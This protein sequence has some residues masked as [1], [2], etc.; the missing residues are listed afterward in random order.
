MKNN[1]FNSIAKP[2]L[3]T[4]KTLMEELGNPHEELKCIHI[5]GTNGKGSVCAF[6]QCILTTAGYKCGKYT[7]PH[8]IDER[9]R[10][11]IDGINITKDDI[12]S[13]KSKVISTAR[14]LFSPN[15]MPTQFEIW[16]ACAFLYFKEQNCDFAIIE[17]GLGGTKDATNIIKNPIMSVITHIALD[18]TQ[19]LG[20]TIKKIA[21]EKAGII[22]Q[23]EYG[24][25]TVT[26]DQNDDIALKV[27]EQ[28]AKE[29]NNTF[30]TATI[31]TEIKSHP[32]Y[33]IFNYK[34]IQNIKNYM[35]GSYQKENAAI[36]IECAKVLKISDEDIKIGISKAKNPGRF[37]IINKSPLIIFD[38]AHNK[39]GMEGLKKSLID[40]FP[41]SEFNFVVAFM[42]DK[43][44]DNIIDTLKI[45]KDNSSFY[46]VELKDNLRCEKSSSLLKK[47]KNIGYS[48]FD[49]KNLEKALNL[50]LSDE[51]ITVI[52]GSLYLY[53]EYWRIFPD[54]IDKIRCK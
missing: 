46:T 47:L 6:L 16:T 45:F 39:N 41:N 54:G 30:I 32:D 2:Q 17:T 49:A 36:A 51:K 33:E 11:T 26:T 1:S 9:E 42:A 21:T 40:L 37:E 34:D 31:P 5:A 15:D 50:C 10:I 48:C 12:T 23:S 44:I 3:I 25:Y 27:L 24:G 28:K 20:N 4:I 29:H 43:D 13:V 14:K 18:H 35:Q 53:E 8:M 38:G 7:S 19:L 52:C 22:K